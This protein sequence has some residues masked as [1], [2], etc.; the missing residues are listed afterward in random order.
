M[1]KP[2]VS[3]FPGNNQLGDFPLSNTLDLYL[4]LCSDQNIFGR[5]IS[6]QNI[7]PQNIFLTKYFW[8]AYFTAYDFLAE[9]FSAEYIS[10]E[11][12][13][14]YDLLAEYFLVSNTLDLHLCSVE[15]KDKQEVGRLL[16]LFL[17]LWTFDNKSKSVKKTK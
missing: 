8:A 4:P 10:A 17:L 3:S 13:S 5:N 11:Y 1:I 2:C 15:E 7:S 6:Q 16:Q 12:F 14:A 9:Y